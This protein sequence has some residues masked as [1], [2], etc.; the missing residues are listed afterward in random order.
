MQIVLELYVY[1]QNSYNAR[2]NS[3]KIDLKLKDNA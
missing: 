1:V 3:V 2:Q